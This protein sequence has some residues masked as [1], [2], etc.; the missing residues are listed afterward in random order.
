MPGKIPPS[1]RAE[2]VPGAEEGRGQPV[3]EGLRL[4]APVLE[5]QRL[6]RLRL[7]VGVRVGV[8]LGQ[9][10]HRRRGQPEEGRQTPKMAPHSQRV[11]TGGA[12]AV[13]P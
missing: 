5:E 2:M 12:A 13:V 3:E 11:T 6:G 9:R 7:A 10:R 4:G 8:R 1:V